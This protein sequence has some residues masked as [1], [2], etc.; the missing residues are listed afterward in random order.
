MHPV[1]TNEMG[2]TRIKQDLISLVIKTSGKVL[3]GKPEH[4]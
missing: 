1:T 4:I 3:N 2:S